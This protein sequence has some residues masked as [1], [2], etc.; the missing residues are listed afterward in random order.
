MLPELI[1][2]T[3]RWFS[4]GGSIL[5]SSG[6]EAGFQPKKL[7][8]CFFL[9]GP[10]LH[11]LSLRFFVI[12]KSAISTTALSQLYHHAVLPAFVI[13]GI[14][15]F[16]FLKSFARLTERLSVILN[17]SCYNSFMGG[18]DMY[19]LIQRKAIIQDLQSLIALYLEDDLG[20]TRE[21][22]MAKVKNKWTGSIFHDDRL[23]CDKTQ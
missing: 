14:W 7:Q 13:R 23:D 1:L 5:I 12:M 4:Q 22:K 10:F 19:N 16:N 15:R 8:H 17:D 6:K 2:V 3:K 9:L 20:K 21:L 18:R 11:R